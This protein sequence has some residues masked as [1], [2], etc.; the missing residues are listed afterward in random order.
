MKS[1]LI[2][3]WASVCL[4][5]WALSNIVRGD[6]KAEWVTLEKSENEVG[7]I[8]QDK[9]IEVIL[10][11][12]N[13]GSIPAVVTNIKVGCSCTLVEKNQRE[14]APGELREIRV[15]IDTGSK[16][17]GT[18]TESVLFSLKS[19]E[20]IQDL[21]ANIKGIVHEDGKL[22]VAPS[23]LLLGDVARGQEF[24]RTIL[25]QSLGT[26][27]PKILETTSPEWLRSEIAGVKEGEWLLK[28]HGKAP[29]GEGILQDKIVVVTDATDFPRTEIPVW[30][31]E[32]GPFKCVPSDVVWEPKN[33][34][35]TVQVNLVSKTGLRVSKI[36]CDS[37]GLPKGY[38]WK[39]ENIREDGT[40]TLTL[41][42]NAKEPTNNTEAWLQKV[43]VTAGLK[44]YQISLNVVVINR[45]KRS[46]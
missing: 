29:L 21:V 2:T 16:A 19:G 1:A 46:E 45:K 20:Q 18:F 12:K 5:A 25:V 26:K 31:F 14:I 17:K 41:Q 38:E 13:S 36:V 6:A 37:F 8:P 39:T 28:V 22:V 4:C 15:Q 34:A 43:T 33:Q 27:V 9:I 30:L 11:L 32:Q 24:A 10:R 3:R 7:A 23:A 44:E 35:D 42:R 40:A